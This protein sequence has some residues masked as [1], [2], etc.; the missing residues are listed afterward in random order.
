M[1]K[2]AGISKEKAEKYWERAKKEANKKRNKLKK[3][4][5]YAYT[6]GIFKKMIGME[7]SGGGIAVYE[8]P[9]ETKTKKIIKENMFVSFAKKL[10][11]SLNIKK[12]QDK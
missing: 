9:H 5:Y 1:A 8:T 10:L 4:S 3:D 6:M 11:E 2:K 7:S 12:T